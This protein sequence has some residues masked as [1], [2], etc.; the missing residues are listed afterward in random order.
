M[1]NMWNTW[2]KLSEIFWNKNYIKELIK[3]T[4]HS[5]G[6]VLG[7]PVQADEYFVDYYSTFNKQI[8]EF[9]WLQLYCYKYC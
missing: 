9:H 6:C 4:I 7:T 8:N 3:L 1:H 5:Y 2:K